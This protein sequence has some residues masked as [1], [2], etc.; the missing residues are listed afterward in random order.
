MSGIED[1]LEL[2]P[3]DL[4]LKL[5]MKEID[6][7]T[8]DQLVPLDEVIGQPRA[9]KALELGLGIHGHGYNI[10]MSGMSGM[11][12]K[13][14]VK[15]MLEKKAKMEPTPA[16]WIYVNNFGQEDR[17]IA[18][19][20][21]AGKAKEL[22]K[23]MEN[24]VNRLKDD[25]PRSFRQEDFSR[26]KQRLNLFYEEQGRNEFSQLEH[27]AQER[28]LII[29]EMPDGRIMLIPR[30]EDRPMSNDEFESLTSEQKDEVTKNQQ[31][32]S[33]KANQVLNKQQEFGRKLRDDVRQVERDFASRIIGPAVDDIAAKFEGPELRDWLLK[34]KDHMLDNL[35]V[36]RDK[37]S[38]QQPIANMF[39]MPLPQP[40][41]PSTEYSIN[42]VVDNSSQKGAPI[43]I[44]ESPNYKN[45]FGTIFGTFDR[46]GRLFTNYNNI[47]AGSL[48]RAN[49]GYLVFN[50]M[51]ALLE[52]L[53]WKELK[54]TLKSGSLEYQMYDPFG[55][56]ATS[57]LRPEPIPL[58]VKLVVV[59]N[60]LLFHLLQ[61]YDEDFP[62]IFK[63]KADFAPEIAKSDQTGLLVGRLINKLKRT[64]DI[65]PFDQ[66]G[67]IELL[68]VGA[69]LAGD[70]EKI[71]AEMSR[72]ADIARESSFWAK[73]E[74]ARIVNAYHVQNAVE[75]KIYRS[76]LIAERIRELIDN[77]TLLIS[78]DGSVTGQV[79][80]LSIIQLGDYMFGRPSRVTA[81]VGVGASGIINIERESR[82][83]G[84]S[85]DKAMLILEGFLRNKYASRHSLA[86]SASIAMEQSYGM[87]EGDSATV[88]ELVCL[89]SAF[90]RIPLRQD[91]AITGS[92]NQWGQ[93]QAVG[94][95]TEK[96]EGFYDICKMKGFSG[97]QGVCIPS[98]N[99]R[100]LI[101]RR[102]VVES[103]REG[104]FH[105]WAVSSVNEA[106]ELLT[107]IPAGDVDEQGT[108]HWR[109]DQRLN[110]ML[111]IAK[112]Q[113]AFPS[114]RE[115]TSYNLSKDGSKDPRPRLPGEE[116]S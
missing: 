86:L 103:V 94:G 4:E 93:V 114:E 51:E 88:A 102:D 54:R 108:F 18:I 52:P 15:Q 30:K 17:P 67:I 109:V 31:D 63:V 26:E 74:E 12:K 104:R 14:M 80:G 11:G 98:S 34:V 37:E 19:K 112:E 81:S 5:D 77:G 90:S 69:R 73:K 39:G 50:I 62:E 32:V 57:S 56:F 95:V 110:E 24:L 78:I 22:K 41:E 46:S 79:N 59:G 83:S 1:R 82:L 10:Y 111:E 115:S 76:N 84:S 20:L 55:V 92:V 60:P 29:Q 58:D 28:N 100:N 33:Q 68:R 61:L 64:N 72:L 71:T 13:G 43:I 9:L 66:S 23:E 47:K 2:S 106:I 40:E 91:I 48:L 49:G 65:L 42:V 107:G 85:F 53:V 87:I 101:L 21:P 105:V 89:L 36:F 97:T 7:E 44:E 45:M 38:T 99:V 3:N 75:E 8:T 116:R 27:L 96:A 113:K 35:G 16:D 6:F 70:K 25:V